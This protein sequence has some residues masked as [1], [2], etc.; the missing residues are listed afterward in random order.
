[1]WKSE[2]PSGLAFLEKQSA[3]LTFHV[4]CWSRFRDMTV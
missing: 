1:M 3:S 2:L 4:A